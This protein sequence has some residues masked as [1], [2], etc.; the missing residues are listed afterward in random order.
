MTGDE[1]DQDLPDPAEARVAELLGSLATSSLEPSP[2]F[3]PALIRR[4]RAQGAVA[5]PLRAFGGFML[6]LA[7][8]ALAAA[9]SATEGRHR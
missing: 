2:A 3:G 1:D 6:A 4:A 7:G 5:P 9:S 8:A